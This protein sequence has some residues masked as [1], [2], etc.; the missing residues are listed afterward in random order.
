MSNV[1]RFYVLSYFFVTKP[2][3]VDDNQ[4]RNGN[5]DLYKFLSCHD[6]WKLSCVFLK[7]TGNQSL[8]ENYAVIDQQTNHKTSYYSISSLDY[9]WKKKHTNSQSACKQ[10]SNI[11]IAWQK[12]LVKITVCHLIV[13]HLTVFLITGTP[14]TYTYHKCICF[15]PVLYCH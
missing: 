14:A 6:E 5:I 4:Y 1:N 8:N 9:K 11:N 15:T 7:S 13:C 2:T 3:R 12:A 10:V